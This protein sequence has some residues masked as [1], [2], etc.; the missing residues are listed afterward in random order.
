MAIGL[1]SRGMHSGLPAADNLKGAQEKPSFT[2]DQAARQLTRGNFKFRD[3]NADGKIEISVK[4]DPSFSSGQQA[5][6][7]NALQYWQDVT[8]IVFKEGA[9]RSD[10]SIDIV[11]D[12][13]NTGGLSGLP[14]PYF[15]DVHTQVGS[16]GA[17]NNPVAGDIFPFVA[18]HEIGHAI[19]L[20]HP[21]E[22]DSWGGGYNTNAVYAQDTHARSVMSYWPEIHQPGHAFNWRRPSGPMLDDIAA[23]QRHYGANTHTR[24][25][26]SVYGFNS[27]SDRP[28]MS[29]KPGD[30]AP[31]FSVWDGGGN[32]TL[33]F[34]GFRQQQ[35]INLMAE[36]FS[37]VGGLKGNISIAKG[38][39]IENAIG[40]HGDDYLK[41][42]SV[43]NRI[44]GGGGADKLFG[45]GGA[46]VFVYDKAS[47]STLG[48]P[49]EILDFTTGTDKI[50]LA[51]AL[52]GAR[53]SSATVVDRFSGR[54]GEIVLSYNHRDGQASL[55]LDLTGNGKADLHIKA[56]GII[57][58]G[59]LFTG[60]L[61][62]PAPKPKPN[63]KTK[64]ETKPETN[65]KT[66]PGN[67]DTVY[68]FNSTTG[69]PT[70]SLHANSKAPKFTVRDSGGNDT[71][72]FS[73]FKQ[74]QTID[75]RAGS[76]SSVGGL[77]G[78]VAIANGVVVE[79]AVG[80][81]GNDVLIGNG[82]NNVLKGGVGSDSLWGVGGANTFIYDKVSES[83]L[84][85]ADLIMDFVSGR[86]KIDLS[87][88]AK[89][90]NTTLQRV[91]TFTGRV[92]DTVVSLHGR[93]G[94]YFVAVDLTGNR[95]TDFL[96]KSP[97]LIKPGDIVGLG[98]KR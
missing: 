85:N 30:G 1:L 24:K 38:V 59:D 31:I 57:R 5:S 73:G 64:P 7:R 51:G 54:A 19:G 90:A 84:Y 56:K 44:K 10:G 37:D 87:A 72:D 18:I 9:T 29:L 78:N 69:D 17:S 53:L 62:N 12:P 49:D 3:R 82:V 11:N 25:T 22:Y 2:T 50:D 6:I 95:Q 68:G 4:I 83:T 46:D 71:L 35:V 45:G 94:R 97:H 27:N 81:S 88:I 43:G 55:S 20:E 52:K 23:I 93:T 34:S 8:N 60:G 67:S 79:N 48:R 63:P 75:L 14:D 86:D 58:S 33:D 28:N 13:N 74:N 40:G 36:S 91:D 16:E 15:A 98:P 76:V 42:N 77:A 32:D 65:P 47:D 61:V 21:G 92:G 41:G 39:V 26:D 80:G 70:T 89:Q 66:K 96:V